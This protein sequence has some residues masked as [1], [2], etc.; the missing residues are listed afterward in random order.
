MAD[1]SKSPSH[2]VEALDIP[3]PNGDEAVR[4]IC[5]CAVCAE[6]GI[7]AIV[8]KAYADEHNLGTQTEDASTHVH[9]LVLMANSPFANAP[10][11]RANGPWAA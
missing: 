5:H 10:Q 8:R 2:A 3:A 4:V 7:S 1:K 9:N 11:M 6:R